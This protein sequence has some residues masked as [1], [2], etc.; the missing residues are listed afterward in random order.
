MNLYIARDGESL[1]P[2]N[3]AQ[4]REYLKTDI[5]SQDDLA[6]A[7]GEENWQPLSALFS[8]PSESILRPAL[9]A[10]NSASS[11]HH[12]LP[13]TTRPSPSLP[14]VFATAFLGVLLAGSLLLIGWQ[15]FLRNAPLPAVVQSPLTAP[16]A[17]SPATSAVNKPSDEELARKRALAL[18]TEMLRIKREGVNVEFRTA[19]AKLNDALATLA[20]GPQEGDGHTMNANVAESARH[21][22]A[23]AW[24]EDTLRRVDLVG[25]HHITVLRAQGGDSDVKRA[26]TRLWAAKQRLAISDQAQAEKN[27]S[28]PFSL[29]DPVDP[30]E[31]THPQQ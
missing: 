16:T 2:Y 23:D 12:V 14:A 30:P 26:E 7:E 11:L 24:A 22:A 25:N 9:D 20:A 28:S 1:G 3:E 29:P 15:H 8:S 18:E 31:P 4:V 13:A 19:K 21:A 17:A 6:C 10:P 27:S 5:F